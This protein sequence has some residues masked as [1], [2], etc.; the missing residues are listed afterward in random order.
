VGGIV[1]IVRAS[2]ARLESSSFLPIYCRETARGKNG[3]G[4][5]QLALLGE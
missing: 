4:A 2:R 1:E 5:A 3:A